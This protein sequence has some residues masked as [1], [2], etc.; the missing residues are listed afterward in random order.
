MAAAQSPVVRE[1]VWRWYTGTISTI[2]LSPNGA[3]VVIASRLHEDDLQ[4][5]LIEKMRSVIG[6]ADQWTIVELP[7]IAEGND[8]IGREA[9]EALWP[10]RFPVSSL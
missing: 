6:D 3:I 2:A 8:L 4:G 10:E 7:A 5:R 9:G 1:G